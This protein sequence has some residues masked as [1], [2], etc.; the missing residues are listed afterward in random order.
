MHVNWQVGKLAISE[1]FQF[2]NFPIPD[3]PESKFKIQNANSKFKT[4]E[5]F[6]FILCQKIYFGS[7]LKE[8]A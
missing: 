7:N 2:T 5:A 6:P 1:T 3:K 8:S 4:Q